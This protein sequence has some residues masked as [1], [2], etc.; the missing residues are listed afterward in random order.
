MKKIVLRVIGGLGNQLFCYAASRRLAIANDAE[1]V[2][3]SKTGFLRDIYKGVYLLDKFNIPCREANYFEMLYPFERYTRGFLKLINRKR[4]FEKRFYIEQQGLIFNEKI[5]SLK[6][7]KNIYIEGLWQSEMYFKDIE[8]TIRNEL[9]LKPLTDFAN[10]SLA[11][12]IKN[13]NSISLHFRW[14]EQTGTDADLF[15]VKK[16]YYM[17]SLKFMKEKVSNPQFFVF[18]D[19]MEKAKNL[20]SEFKNENFTFVD[21]NEKGHAF[22][23]KDIWLMNQCKHFI[24]ANSTLSWWGAW[25]GNFKD[26]IIITPNITWDGSL[27]KTNWGFPGLIPDSWIKI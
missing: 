4:A 20:L 8:P 22:A 12:K 6:P 19:N 3:D 16:D 21:H 17:R 13:T 18:S 23:Y 9:S 15:T 7:E 5:L 10:L 27:S 24:T 26:K 25:L 14:F 1:L 2:L 11:E